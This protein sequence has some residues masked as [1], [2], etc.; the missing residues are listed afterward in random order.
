MNVNIAGM[1][2]YAVFELALP[3]LFTLA[4]VVFAWGMFQYFIA[5]GHDE[6]AREKGKS[7]MM[8]GV[9]M[10]VLMIIIWSAIAWVSK[11]LGVG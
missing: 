7:L 9:L 10:L 2:N 8:Y 4:F 1:L 3:L 6:E 5:G 11:V